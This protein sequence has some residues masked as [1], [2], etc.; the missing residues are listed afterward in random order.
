[1][2]YANVAGNTTVIIVDLSYINMLLNERL[3]RTALCLRLAELKPQ[4]NGSQKAKDQV[5]PVSSVEKDAG[6]RRTIVG[7]IGS[8]PADRDRQPDEGIEQEGDDQS[9]P[10]AARCNVYRIRPAGE[11]AV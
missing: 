10:V 4:R 5:E 7:A 9:A 2:R 6:V 8:D 3:N 11:M 1:M